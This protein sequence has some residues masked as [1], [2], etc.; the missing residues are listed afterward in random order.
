LGKA[1]D[2]AAQLGDFCGFGPDVEAKQANQND[3]GSGQDLPFTGKGALLS[4]S[5]RGHTDRQG[6]QHHQGQDPDAAFAPGQTVE[7]VR[8]RWRNR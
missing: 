1:P 4:V 3:Q 7:T 8:R 2:Q 5:N 6:N